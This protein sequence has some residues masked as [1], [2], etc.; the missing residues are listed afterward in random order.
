MATADTEI[1][2]FSRVVEPE[3]RDLSPDAARS[4]LEMGFPSQDRDRMNFLDEKARQGSL[5]P[6]ED[7]ELER[8]LHVG[9][10]LAVMK[11][12]ARRSRGKGDKKPRG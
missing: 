12:K 5:S 11:S 3:K 6:D 7:A 10:M 9:N 2:I 8:Y 1:D 4:I